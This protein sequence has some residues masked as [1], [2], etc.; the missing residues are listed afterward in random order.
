VK[1]T[2]T[3]SNVAADAK[4]LKLHVILAEHELRFSG[5]NGIR[6]HPM[7]VRGVA[8]DDKPGLPV[9]LESGKATI[10]HTFDLAT[11]RE[12]IVKSLADEIAK[13]REQTKA[14]P[15]PPT[16]RAEGHAYTEIDTSALAVVVFLQDAD[17]NVLQAA[18]ADVAPVRTKR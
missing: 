14:A 12:Q 16:Y 4:D 10:T 17:R 9:T 18:R 11:I 7:A 13:R 3:V 6:F 2:A 1:M 15:V 8:G 5:E